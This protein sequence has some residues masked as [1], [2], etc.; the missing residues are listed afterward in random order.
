MEWLEGRCC[1]RCA[2]AE[3]TLGDDKCLLHHWQKQV[4]ETYEHPGQDIMWLANHIYKGVPHL[5]VQ[6]A[7]DAF[8]K[9]LPE[10]LRAPIA[11]ANPKSLNECVAS[12]TKM[13]AVLDPGNLGSMGSVRAVH[14]SDG[15]TS[16]S[17][18]NVVCFKCHKK[19]HVA[20]QCR[21]FSIFIVFNIVPFHSCLTTIKY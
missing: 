8:I 2:D 5:T 18:A 13:Y 16:S 15:M 9:A 14:A 19:G 21:S 20:K 7:R 4:D 12:V 11:A 1:H 3:Q 17:M 10:G 6:E